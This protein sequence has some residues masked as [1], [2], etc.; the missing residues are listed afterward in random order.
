[1][2][3]FIG[4]TGKMGA[5]KDSFA[6]VLSE[7][8]GISTYALASPIKTYVSYF[9]GW[10]SECENR[11]IKETSIYTRVVSDKELEMKLNYFGGYLDNNLGGGYVIP[12]TTLLKMKFLQVFDKYLVHENNGLYQ[13]C[14]SPRRAY[15]LMGTEF[16]RENIKDS[17]WVDIAPKAD[18]IWTDL[19][20][21][22]EAQALVDYDG[23]IIEV[24]REGVEGDGHSSEAGIGHFKRWEVVENNKTLKALERKARA[25]AKNIKGKCYENV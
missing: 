18:V 7:E 15:Q 16:A 5:G 25:I 4:I 6:K 12:D 9:F 19:R 1:M 10:G 22:N 14:I 11:T 17:I 3:N 20:F 8:L 23:K 21:E 24:V 13:W 2:N